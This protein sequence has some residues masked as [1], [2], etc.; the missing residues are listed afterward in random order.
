MVTLNVTLPAD[1]IEFVQS[2]IANGGYAS[3]DEVVC[4]ALRLLQHESEL[5]EE[6][7]AI[8]RRE[9]AVGLA[10]AA[11]GRMSSLTISE[12]AD[13]VLREELSKGGNSKN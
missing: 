8:L 2:E 3:A 1:L 12:I 6:K 9:I 11:A 13:E 5:E 7:L 10:D 4:E